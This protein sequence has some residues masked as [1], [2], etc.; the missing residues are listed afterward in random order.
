MLHLQMYFNTEWLYDQNMS[1]KD[2]LPPTN[3]SLGGQHLYLVLTSMCAEQRVP[4]ATSVLLNPKPDL[5]N[6]LVSI[7]LQGAAGHL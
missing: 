4:F 2:L 1:G 6:V 7:D 3:F 5:H